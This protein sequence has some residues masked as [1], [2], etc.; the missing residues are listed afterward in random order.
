MPEL[1]GT[2]KASRDAR[3]H[4][5]QPRYQVPQTTPCPC[6]DYQIW[7]YVPSHQRF[8][9]PRRSPVQQETNGY[10][11][12]SIY[13]GLQSRDEDGTTKARQSAHGHIQCEHSAHSA[14]YHSQQGT[15]HI[16]CGIVHIKVRYSAHK[17][18][19][20]EQVRHS[21]SKVQHKA[22]EVWHTAVYY[23]CRP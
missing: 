19:H 2:A 1:A 9:Y 16:Q 3:P 11:T 12:C 22:H 7:R 8:F 18:R 4:A 5:L 10:T 20:S 17:V 23:A 13:S 15:V 14:A 21:T 6:P